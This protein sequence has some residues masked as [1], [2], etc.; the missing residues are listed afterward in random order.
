MDGVQWT[1]SNQIL[2]TVSIV[3]D[4]DITFGSVQGVA[5]KLSPNVLHINA[6]LDFLNCTRSGGMYLIAGENN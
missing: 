2:W 5:L 1:L 4:N 6:H 3:F